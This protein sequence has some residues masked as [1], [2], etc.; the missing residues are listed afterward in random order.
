MT[1]VTNIASVSFAG[2]SMTIVI[3]YPRDHGES[4]VRIMM[5]MVMVM[6][7]MMMM[8]MMMMMMTLN[9]IIMIVTLPSCHGSHRD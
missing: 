4:A 2:I 5:R 1:I 6:M 3:V 7:I 8:M 9:V